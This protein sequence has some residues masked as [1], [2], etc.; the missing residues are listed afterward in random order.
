LGWIINP[1]HTAEL[2]PAQCEIVCI[3]IGLIPT[4]FLFGPGL[5]HSKTISKKKSFK[6][7]L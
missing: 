2:S 4:Q 3:F 1:V 5:A 7:N 6:K